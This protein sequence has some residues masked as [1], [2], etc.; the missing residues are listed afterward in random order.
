MLLVFA[1]AAIGGLWFYL[2]PGK[3][4]DLMNQANA[5]LA[6]ING[7]LVALENTA[8]KLTAAAKSPFAPENAALPPDSERSGMV[9]TGLSQDKCQEILPRLLSSSGQINSA[10]LL[11]GKP[12]K[13][14]QGCRTAN[15]RIE[16]V[17]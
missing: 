12:V 16:V 5:N 13:A 2:Q 11:N 8:S 3:A 9:F 1:A 14:A 7:N 4:N 6:S 15:N 17:I 10:V